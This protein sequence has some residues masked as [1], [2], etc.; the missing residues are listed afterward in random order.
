MNGNPTLDPYTRQQQVAMYQG[1]QMN[2]PQAHN[3]FTSLGTG[4]DPN[5]ATGTNTSGQHRNGPGKVDS[6]KEKGKGR[7]YQQWQMQ[8][9]PQPQTQSAWGPTQGP[10]DQTPNQTHTTPES[11][12]TL[13][14]WEKVAASKTKPVEAVEGKKKKKKKTE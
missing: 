6:R 1:W 2:Q 12:L 13:A 3:Q 7:G 10:P 5:Q 14:Q 9:Q 8:A 11:T 4:A